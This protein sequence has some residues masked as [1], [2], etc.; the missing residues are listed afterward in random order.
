MHDVYSFTNYRMLRDLLKLSNYSSLQMESIVL[1][2][3]HCFNPQ[4]SWSSRAEF[5]LQSIACGVLVMRAEYYT[6]HFVR[7]NACRVR[8]CLKVVVSINIMLRAS[9]IGLI[10]AR[11]FGRILARSSMVPVQ[12][13][14]RNPYTSRQSCVD[15]GKKQASIRL[16][17][18]AIRGLNW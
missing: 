18:A 17:Q 6:R 5:C 15:L 11:E 7:D 14:P 9:E 8:G 12:L 2:S 3:A 1:Y 10:S 4:T 16:S 13:L